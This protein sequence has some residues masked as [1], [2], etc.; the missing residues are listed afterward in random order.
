MDMSRLN[1]PL[2]GLRAFDA[3]A[4]HLS[5]TRA[6]DEL[7][8]TQA[9]ISHQVRA[10]EDRLGRRLFTR[11]PR[12]LA[13]TD[14]GLALLQP[15]VDGFERLESAV[16][17]IREGRAVQVV[18]VGVVS[19]FAAG[20][21]VERLDQ[22]AADL[23]QLDV[24]LFTHNNRVDLAA[25]GL[26]CAI[27]FGDGA[28][29]GTHA[30]MLLEAPMSAVCTPIIASTLASPADLLRQRLI[31]SYR[32]EEWTR[33]FAAVGIEAPTLRGPVFDSSLAMVAAAEQGVGVALVPP[34]MFSKPLEGGILVQPFPTAIDLGAYWLTWLKS[35]QQSQA[36]RLFH[37]WLTEQGVGR[38]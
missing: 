8:V 3:A 36:L 9:A 25:D 5:F 19:T 34:V 22:L 17:R 13:L 35:R 21:L 26:D 31:R 16:D 15:V 1:L 30:S 32:S 33:W 23:P 10:L 28:W 29:H 7:G 24:R 12:G 37:A 20:W 14:E 18:N 27:R 2:N 38:P 4:R 11:L 6:A